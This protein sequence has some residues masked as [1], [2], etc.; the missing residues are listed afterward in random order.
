M[1][2]AALQA[3]NAGSTTITASVSNA[4]GVAA[5]DAHPITVQPVNQS[6][7]TVGE[8]SGDGYLNATEAQS[9]LNVSGFTSGVP[10]GTVVTVTL[11]GRA[12]TAT[13]GADGSWSV[14]IPAADLQLLPQG[15]NLVRATVT[16][17]DGTV[18]SNTSAASLNVDTL[19]PDASIN[20]PFGDG[21]LSGGEAG[22]TQTLTGNTG[23]TGPGQ[24]VT[25]TLNGNQY[26]GTVNNDG[27]WSVSLPP[28]ALQNLPQGSNAI[29]VVVTDPAGNSSTTTTPVNVVTAPPGLSVT[30]PQGALNEDAV[31]A[32]LIVNG[33]SNG[34]ERVTL[35]L[36]GVTY[37]TT[38][39]PDGTWSIS[40]PASDLQQL[41]DQNYTVAVTSTD[42]F[43]NTAT[44]N[45]TLEVDTT[46]PALTV[47]TISGDGFVNAGE[48]ALPLQ[49]TGTT[50]PGSTVLV[51]F[52]SVDVTAT[53]DPVT[54]AWTATLT[55]DIKAGLAD[56][57]YI[58]TVI[59]TDAAGNQ[60][61]SY[62]SVTF[63]TDAANLPSL[64]L[65]PLT[66]DDV[67]NGSE[68]T[69]DQAL[70]G[71]ASN[72]QPGRE[73]TLTLEG[74][75]TY[76]GTVLAGGS[77][78]IAL[79]ADVLSALENGTQNYTVSVS[80]IAGNRVN[81]NGS[82]EVAVDD[83][84]ASLSVGVIAGDN[85]LNTT[86]AQSDLIISG[87]S[88]NLAENTTLTVTFNDKTYPALVNANGG[89]S[90]SVPAADLVGI[91][92]G[93][94]TVTVTGADTAGD[95]VSNESAL[96]V[97]TNFPDNIQITAPFGDGI[98]NA[99]ETDTPQ[100]LTGSTGVA[101][102]D[103]TVT[104]TINGEEYPATVNPA[105]GEWQ[106]TLLPEILKSLPEGNADIVVT[107]RDSLG[108]EVSASAPV[109]VD[110]SAPT[111][112][113]AALDNDG[114][115]NAQTQNQP[116]TLSGTAGAGSTIT[117]V[118]NGISYA[119]GTNPDGSWSLD[120]APSTLQALGDGRY[121]IL[122]T[123]TDSSG[124]AT[125]V[126]IPVTLDTLA[127]AVTFAPVGGD[128]YLNAIEHGQPLT[129]NG[130]A[131]TG[132]TVV[133]TLNGV[134]YPATSDAQ[135]NWSV[136]VP[137]DAVNNLADGAYTLSAAA[138]DAAGNVAEATQPL[139]VVAAD[140]NLPAISVDTFTSD[141]ILDGAEKELSQFITGTTL[142]VQA[143]QIVTL[144]LNGQ[145]Y[146]GTVQQGGS[147]SV[148]VPASALTGLQNGTQS[149]SVA[150]S[151]IAG[152]SASGTGSFSVDDSFSAIAIGIISDDN[153]LNGNEAQND[154]VISGSSRFVAFGARI[155]MRFNNTDYETTA[156][157]DG[158]WNITVPASALAGLT[159]GELL[160]TATA[161]DVNGNTIT[162][163]RSLT[164]DVN[165]D[166]GITLDPPFGDG[167]LN[168]AESLADQ[169]LTGTTGATGEGQSISLVIG[170]VT[171]TGTVDAGG[172]WAV[173]L[174]GAALQALPE[175]SNTLNIT[176][177]DQV[178][179]SSSL[180]GNVNVDT[181]APVLTVDAISQD[182]RLSLAELSET[183]TLTGTGTNGDVITLT[184][185][186]QDYSATVNTAGAWSIDI[187][188]AALGGLTEGSW[189]FTIVATDPSGNQTTA[190]RTVDVD[191][192]PPLVT[193]DAVSGDGYLNVAEGN[194]PL[195][196]SGSGEEGSSIAVELNGV[197]YT[198]VAGTD[199]AWSLTIPANIVNG[200][201][202]GSYT[203]NVTASDRAGNT[204]LT[205]TPLNVDKSAP[206]I[207]VAD[208]TA[209]NIL[210]GAEQQVDQVISGTASNVEAGQTLTVTLNGVDYPTT[211][212]T[213]G[214]W[215]VVLPAA[216][217]T[218]LANGSQ[219]LTVTVT[220]AAGNTGT[221]D[222]TFSVDNTISSIAI[223]PLSGDG[224]LNAVEAGSELPVTGITTNV[225]EGSVV[226]FTLG[227]VE[228]TTTV[229]ADGS[230]SLT[231]PSAALT[232]LDDGLQ[233]ATVSV[234]ASNGE[235]FTGSGTLN[236]LQ[237]SLPAPTL[238]TPFT[239]GTLTN[240]EATINQTLTGETGVQGAG[241][242]VTVT[243]AGTDYPATVNSAGVWTLLLTPE[244]LQALPQGATTITVTATDVAGNTATTA[245]VPIAIDTSLPVF[246][247]DPLAGGDGIL[248]GDEQDNPLAISGTGTPG[249]TI[250]VTLNAV[251][252]AATVGENGSW[253]LT[254]PPGDLAELADGPYTLTLTATDAAGNATT[255]NESLNVDTAAP[256]FTFD[257]IAEDN[258]IDR[259]EQNQPLIITGT[260]SEGD[261]ITVTLGGVDYP[262]TVGSDGTWSLTV[263]P[264]ELANLSEGDNSVTV[265][266]TTPAG[267]SQSQTTIVALDSSVDI[268]LI[269][270]TI[271]GDG[272]VN[273]A[274]AAAGFNV[275]GS[276]PD[277]TTTVVVTING[278]DYPATVVAN[279]LWS[280]TIP[281]G[282]LGALADNAY[283]V[284]VTATVADGG[285]V[286]VPSSVILDTTAPLF[287]LAT[288][289]GDGFLNQAGQDQPLALS[290]TGDAGDS[291]RVTLNGVPYTA[292]VDD[293]GN[294]S[295]T[296][297]ATD[298]A[299]LTDG[300]YQV[301][302]T[303]TDPAGNSTTQSSPLTVD[304]TAP[305]LVVNPVSGDGVLNAAEQGQ[306]L[307]VSG[308]AESGATITVTLENQ[309]YTATAG[310]NGQWTLAIPAADLAALTNGDYTL[311]VVATDPAGNTTLTDT[312]LTVVADA[313]ALPVL[314]L[315][316]FAGNAILDAA[317]QQVDQ[318]LSGTVANVEAG[319]TVT[320]TLNGATYSGV[321]QASGAWSVTLPAA[322]LAGL[323]DGSQSYT[324]LVEDAAGN[325]A[326]ATGSFEV[327]TLLSGLAFN[328]IGG[329]GYLNAEEALSDLTISGTSANVAEGS[330][331]IVTLNGTDYPALVGP[332]GTWSLVV[333]AA[334]LAALAEGPLTVTVSGTDAA[335]NPVSGEATLNVA[336][337][338]PVITPDTLFGDGTLNA[339]E[340]LSGQTLSGSTGLTGDG[341]TVSVVIN[342]TT[343]PGTVDNNGTW[344][345]SVPA[346]ILQALP[347]GE[348]PAAVT[349]SDAAGN[350]VTSDVTLNV[351]TLPPALTVAELAGDGILNA[352]EQGNDLTVNGT[353]EADATLIVTLNGTDYTTTMGPDG[354]WTLDIPAA[355]LAGLTDGNYTLNVTATDAA[356]NSTTVN[357]PLTVKADAASLPELTV[358]PFAGN[359]ILDGAEQQ[360]AQLL[361]GSTSNVEPGQ[362]VTVTLGDQIYTTQ[363][364]ADG[365][366][367]LSVPAAALGQL[368]DG[369][370]TIGIAVSDV[371][372]N[373]VSV[374]RALTVNS[375]TSGIGIDPLSGDGFLN[376]AEAQDALIVT[377]TTA[378]VAVGSTVTIDFNGQT[379]TGEVGVNG[380]WNVIIPAASLVGLQDGNATLTAS[381]TDATGEPVS[382]S[383]TLD[384]RV[385]QLPQPVL[386]TP[387]TDGVLNGSEAAVTQTLTGN[388]GVT[389][390]GQTISLDINGET[391][392]GVVD[393]D[394]NWSISVPATSLQTLPQ[395]G[396]T[397]EITVSDAAG[398]S[399]TLPVPVVVDTT[400]PTLS[401]NPIAGDGVINAG[402]AAEDITVSGGSTGAEAGQ[403]VTVSLYGQSFTTTTDADG[404][405]SLQLPAGL[406]TNAPDGS[407]PIAVTLSDAAGNPTSATVDVT[408]STLS[409][410]PTIITPFGDSFLNISESQADQVLSGT[411]GASGANQSV[412]VTIAGT[413]YTASVDEN[414]NWTLPV[415]AA[416][417]QGLDNGAQTITVTATDAQGNTG[418]MTSTITVDLVAPTLQLNPVAG[419]NIINAA[420]ILQPVS[421]TGTASASEAGQ[422]VTVT[423][424]GQSYQQVVQNDG[425]WRLDLPSDVTQALA[426][427]V[428]P[429]TVTL[430]DS[431]GNAITQ[432][433][434]VTVQASPA[435]L[436]TIAVDV[437][438]QDDYIN[439]AEA[440]QDLTLSGSTT[441]VGAGQ[442][443]TVV[444]NGI[445]YTAT[446]QAN[447]SW[448]ATVP[449]AD[450]AAL[451]DGAQTLSVSVSDTAGNPASSTRDITKIAQ[452]ASQPT[453]TIDPVTGDDVLNVTEA[454]GDV[455]ITG[456]SQRIPAGET[457]TVTLNGNTYPATVD[458][459]GNWSATIP[460]ADAQALAQGSNDLTAT[461]NDVAGN[462]ATT[463]DSFTVDTQP[464]LLT[465]SLGAGADDILNLA[466]ALV[467]LTVSGT[468]DAGL[469]VNVTLNG[470][471]YSVT[472]GGDGSWSLVIPASDLLLL[473]DGS[474]DVGVS[475]TDANGNTATDLLE[476]GVAINAPPQLTLETPFVDGLLNATEAAADQV[477]SGT[478]TNLPAGTAIVVT[479]GTLTFNGTVGADNSWS[480]TIPAGELTPLG[481]GAFQVSV[482]AVDAA[483][484]PASAETSI[485]LLVTDLPAVTIN[486][487]FVD[488]LLNATEAGVDQILSGTTGITGEGQT[489]TLNIDGRLPLTTTVDAQG[490][491]SVT[492]TPSQL[493]DIGNG[494]HTINVTVSDR[495]GN[496][497]SDD[498]DFTAIITG[499]PAPT[500]VTPFTDG[501]LNAV[502]AAQGGVL[503]GVTGIT[504]AQSVSINVNGT[505]YAA[506]VDPATGAWSLP[507]PASL[508]TTLPDGSWPI[509]VTVTDSVGN[510]GTADGSLLVAINDLPDVSI[511]LPFGDG[512]LNVAEAAL[513][514]VLSGS[515][516]KIAPGQTVT[517]SIDG[518]APLE[519][520][521]NA[522]GD[523][524]LTLSPADL[525]AL[526]SGS[527][528]VAVTAT[529]S[530]G[531]S[532]TDSLD[533]AARLEL[534]VPTITTPFGDGTLNISEAGAAITLTGTTGVTGLNQ[535]VQLQIDVGGTIYTGV[536]NEQ[537][538]WSVAL[539]AGALRGLDNGLHSI[540]VTVIDPA[541]NT[542][543][544]SLDFTAALTPPVPVLN[545][546]FVDGFLNGT[547]VTAGASLSGT[548]GATG[549]GQSVTVTL[550]GENYTLE[551]AADG[552]WTLELTPL[553]LGALPQGAQNVTVLATDGAGNSASVTGSVTV[554]TQAPVITL[555]PFTGDDTLTYVESLTNQTLSGTVTGASPGQPV[556]VTIGGVTLTGV[557]Q[558]G[559]VWSV[560]VPPAALAALGTGATG[561]IAVA[562]TDVAGNTGT[563]NAIV[564][565]DL[566]VPATPLFT[567]APVSGDNIINAGD[568][569]TLTIGGTYANLPP[570]AGEEGSTVTVT[571]NGIPVGTVVVNGPE[572][573]WSITVPNTVATLPEG[574][575]EIVATLVTPE[576]GSLTDS[577]ALIVDRVPPALTI[578]PVTG[579]GV[580]NG[581]EAAVTQLISGTAPVSEAGRA[582]TLTL[583]G[584]SYTAI[585]QGDGS[586][587]A[588]VPAGDLQ[589]LNDQGYQISASLTDAAGNTGTADATV[590]VDTGGPLLQ[591]DALLGNNVLN[592][593]DILTTQLL[594]GTASGAEGQ[595]IGLYLGDGSPIATAIVNED[596]TFSLDLTPQVLGS[597]TEGT[598]VF[599]LR[600]SDAS[601][602]QT[603]ATL[604]VNKIVNQAL[605]LV[606]DSV[607]GDGF[608]N[609]VDTTVAQVITGVATSAGI[610]AIVSLEIGGTTLEA[611][612]GQDGKFALIVPPSVLGLLSG[613]D[614]ELNLVL[615]D[616]AGN[617][618]TVGET[619]TAILDNPVIG[620][621]TGLFGGDNL[622]SIV[623][624]GLAQTIGGTIDAAVGSDVTVTLGSKSYTTKL[625]AGG[626]WSLTIPPLDL[627]ALASGTLAL[628]VKVV[629]PAGNT[630]SSSVNIGILTQ[631]PSITLSPLFGDGILNIADALV[632]QTISGTVNNVAAGTVVRLSIGNTTVDA[633]VGQNGAF[634]ATVTP[635]ILG[636]LTSGNITVGASLTDAAG[637]TASTSL[638]AVVKLNAPV[639]SVNPL[640]G[641]GLLNVA[642]AL[643]GQ[644]IGGTITGAEPGSRVVITVAGTQFVTTTAANGSFNIGLSPA[645]LQGLT[646]GNLTVG[647]S[648]TDSAGNTTSTTAG[649]IVGVQ[650]LPTITLNPLFGDGVLNLLES[651][652]TQTI[653]GTVGNVAGGTTVTIRLGNTSVTAEVA[654]NGTFSAAISPDIL[655]TLLD[656][657]LTVGVSVTDRVG[658]TSSVN[659]GLKVGI[660]VSPAVTVNTIFGDGVLSAADLNSTQTISGT[661]TNVTAGS[662]ISV[663]LGGKAYTTTVSGN[664][665]WSLSVPKTDLA[666]L[667]NGTQTV[668]VT[669]TDAYGNTAV[670][671]GTLN[672]IAQTPPTITLSSIFGDGLLNAAD[673][674]TAQTI[675]GTTTNAEGATIRVNVGATSLTTTVGANG[676][677]SVSVP[678]AALAALPDGTAQ[679]TATLTN[680]AGNTGTGSGTA[681][682]GIQTLPTVTL[683]PS[684]VF[685]GDHY[686]NLTEANTAQTIGGTS[687]NA[688]GSTVAVNV[689]GNVFTTTVGAN[690]S[691]SV[692]LPSATLRGIADGS[693]TVSVTLTDRV[694][695]TST[696][697]DTFVA[698]TNNLP[699]IGV[700]PVL[701][702]VSVLLTGLTISGGTL[703]LPQGTLLN[704]TL[705]GTTRQATVDAL[706][707]YSVKFTGGVLTALSLN[708]IVTVAAVDPAGNQVSTST[709]LLLGSLLPTASATALMAMA[710]DDAGAASAMENRT[711][712]SGEE[713]ATA[714]VQATTVD[715]TLVTGS[716]THA[717]DTATKAAATAEESVS[718]GTTPAA[719][720]DGEY[721][722][723]GVIITLADG[724]SVEGASVTGSSG[725]DLVMLNTLNFDHIDGGAGTD[726]LMLTG[727]NMVLDLT[728]LG[729]KI[730]NVEIIDLGNAGNNSIK[731][732]LYEA[733]NLTDNP[734]E[735]LMIKGVTGDRV[736]LTN[737]DEGV[738]AT[739]GQRTV[740]GQVYDVYHNSALSSDNTLGDVLV[741]H[742]LQVH[743]V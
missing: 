357:A 686:L 215:Q 593:T 93:S 532:N 358:N 682:V 608:L 213:G 281:A 547:E 498:L 116:L 395:G 472:A 499:L 13:T 176:V 624:A 347:Q 646:D 89:W 81:Q 542:N 165:P 353:G 415:T 328:P 518:G 530:A 372:G 716:D 299:T 190:I 644:A 467:G 306:P 149:Y 574:T 310:Q 732:D 425:S 322:A 291:I 617:T 324:V 172:N 633:T 175:G 166:F 378:N 226:T 278:V 7:I 460:A 169:T 500:L 103:Q 492:L 232:A 12:Y 222:K 349:V 515:T 85:A 681:Q 503:T 339:S 216:A 597:L 301:S 719:V 356:G 458:A 112:T 434:S 113:V 523:W 269:V 365:S 273:A 102:S 449:A 163:T 147:W 564:G 419:D 128:S 311:T 37:T 689:A 323:E 562:I 264:A 479:V 289:S 241:Q 405:W 373:P 431:A 612:V 620:S 137:A 563:A 171:Y 118:L 623:E 262:A 256:L 507:L 502:E 691:W 63:I 450:V 629:D 69:L 642:D 649:A 643:L 495:A 626:N 258:I 162:T 253:S 443:V 390:N 655:G 120:I 685:G 376:A 718:S 43:G 16:L 537:G 304:L 420:E 683:T 437:V 394:G 197:T 94:Y 115:V 122:V 370:T 146:S 156:N 490:R 701:S 340:A 260:G 246:T 279:G 361:S 703:N 610:G 743:V 66:A 627:A 659:A 317:E 295:V 58:V 640:F 410:Q 582:V 298:L 121:D 566:A 561:E 366:W 606:V 109:S 409:L 444:L 736:T 611:N 581:S 292:T 25:V 341:Q 290:G 473:Q 592:A 244:V 164:S 737:G 398:N 320:V 71:T 527:H 557:V 468:T 234:V 46:P 257:P 571:I 388:T 709:T 576:A 174:P 666:A 173:V 54:G 265:T 730:E 647:V 206:S 393:A 191:I 309:D 139:N 229:E 80:D 481:D 51:R 445:S 75:G 619:V 228:Y 152:N 578:N 722:I 412:L 337:V 369:T 348:S 529:D 585:V 453:I 204:T 486:T 377:G 374:T 39:N 528:N 687:T 455:T 327:N 690:G 392:T 242:T 100:V 600:V 286:S 731:L 24:T 401:L 727:D 131:E 543:T 559:G 407:Y 724:Q 650:N 200:L 330:T 59:A 92:N 220:D 316:D 235:T 733:L 124:N 475:V 554:D 296:V 194:Q 570:S 38:V 446:V 251:E 579:D 653:S 668:N 684:S 526:G 699:V 531:N 236:V 79:P 182:N 22:T 493:A 263:P 558:A 667:A 214:A 60:S 414:G 726:T 326:T 367:S 738:W 293:A 480:V 501:V 478:A 275:T 31:N 491:W 261:T 631:Q 252:Y 525:A 338:L 125:P 406:L 510:V 243:I 504:G 238:Q 418:V 321:V 6:S 416:T 127:P 110:T 167:T 625:T 50:T 634:T 272:V 628:G 183:L 9:P 477:I 387:F 73:I 494:T 536:V 714:T 698:V 207:S 630:A 466:E 616:A 389:G 209:N 675:S 552:S 720:D 715:S 426:D 641:D 126:Q 656:G 596:G 18:I 404:N 436:P 336:T 315:N 534:P 35:T 381:A 143:G 461:G 318:Q 474:V 53:V 704:V 364:Q 588:S 21:V 168:G 74:G 484:N 429:V 198:T 565:L 99:A 533:F 432:D 594:T 380:I 313:D 294:W 428:Y 591:V 187:P 225:A 154:L 651:L 399:T 117:V 199:G 188:A 411:T 464:P 638:G 61:E 538:N 107:V 661:A 522:N 391:L 26:T 270:N 52:D 274:E 342:G 77:W 463:T 223:S 48:M 556:T 55:E 276:V 352:V 231:V 189:D 700:D 65:N 57:T 607:F 314:T 221:A 106:L 11:G 677:W 208:V 68:V 247:L 300:D 350:S 371:A 15:S 98:L 219:T 161:T 413:D 145:Q 599:G 577:G 435:S 645:I 266:A 635:D 138:T 735:D 695:N 708:S 354:E 192:T 114:L 440:G 514:Q 346:D 27:S 589:Q 148:L 62:T 423:F 359:D 201:A 710:V 590:T 184:L 91:P 664:G 288:P 397:L 177:T 740:D 178:G 569:D 551:A 454:Q 519:A 132:A 151:D 42:A 584:K 302:V 153:Q 470:N 90:V 665:G 56:G 729:L 210:D 622:L 636:T 442:I 457:I 104:V 41:P 601:G 344:S 521:V 343:L 250:T 36:N 421:I 282:A 259:A 447:G 524:S 400:A 70:T 548:T 673:A 511:N 150:V 448:S 217:L 181:L 602:N 3:L 297:P 605:N 134:D 271:S 674:L 678:A 29:S 692:S 193:V 332:D 64:T 135:G 728:S 609:A 277:N 218:A 648:V 614:L 383:A 567:L 212:Q 240:A 4:A 396:N 159:P 654:P 78:S 694:G 227:G 721:S 615:T 195:V 595:T 433:L 303:A 485:E 375:A 696:A 385:N 512:Q 368:A 516:G 179:N 180:S 129:L 32:P 1:P 618:R 267:N 517:V 723:G 205:T 452:D 34:G 573:N 245:G 363:V 705:N 285:S 487:P 105:T 384:V 108:N 482:T 451:D 123:A 287:T 712:N 186:G 345:I 725:E 652:V 379:F 386:D 382:S 462:P 158:S 540:D 325:P 95:P 583:N 249:E 497:S 133:V 33:V 82:F 575:L 237:D 663:S 141:G 23:A 255:L 130:T 427:G 506:T 707:R 351:D 305:F 86:E 329:D 739:A 603:D 19:P 604:T 711:S 40:V 254:I 637:N 580:L 83:T 8:L 672:V 308:S 587:S 742:N 280:A 669:V 5:S 170:A 417:L 87:S 660:G 319:Q 586:W 632:N 360:T 572:G 233:T 544:G 402:E 679:V 335:G 513:D 489:I 76:S 403:L 422:L 211:V 541:G 283:P 613:G 680:A 268:A 676:A 657:N 307:T 469:D 483:G 671:S 488:G 697:S 713:S 2:S 362:T 560:T 97:R 101:F 185:N 408:L 84:A 355:D 239:D 333:T 334:D 476:L 706:G 438:S 598:L 96:T 157:A 142:N 284:L 14:A 639:I 496:T 734:E 549:D 202:D 439:R 717:T 670:N 88:S 508:L 10:A 741:Q 224:Y 520:T 248:N 702:L 111:L 312:P 196:V 535:G 119:T 550:G 568:A 441:N 662:A 430:N 140:A 47:N 545:T 203:L 28:S 658:N 45:E 621:L 230:W 505:A 72:V 459:E 136:T 688:V 424:N 693:H 17:A 160:V 553:Q 555:L 67:L 44:R 155:F 509:T 471:T 20:L 49:I 465:V 30:L 539:P 331:L 546:P 144:T 456:T